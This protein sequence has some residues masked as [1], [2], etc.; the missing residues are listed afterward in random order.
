MQFATPLPIDAVLGTLRTALAEPYIVQARVNLPREVYPSL[1]G[2]KV[3][4]L[5]RML[6]TNPYCCYGE[7]MD[8]CLTRISTAA[9]L[10][11]TAG[12]GSTVPTFL[13]ER[14]P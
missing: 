7:F 4:F 8:S 14:R 9:L 5:E 2:G 13:V 1:A 3:Q 11:V 10:N 6:D 12:G